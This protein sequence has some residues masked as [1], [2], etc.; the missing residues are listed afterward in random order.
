MTLKGVFAVWR[1]SYLD[2]IAFDFATRG[3][4]GQ[5]LPTL[6][7]AAI[8]IGAQRALLIVATAVAAALLSSFSRTAISVITENKSSAD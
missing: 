2:S 6:L 5:D 1:R 3:V 4:G 8:G 7:S